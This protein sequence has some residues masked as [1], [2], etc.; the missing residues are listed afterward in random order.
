[1]LLL[2]I[3]L[4]IMTA[5]KRQPVSNQKQM[6]VLSQTN[7]KGIKND[8][9]E[10][11][12][13][14]LE[15]LTSS[16]QQQSSFGDEREGDSVNEIKGDQD[17]MSVHFEHYPLVKALQKLA[18]FR[19]LNIIISKSVQGDLSLSLEGVLWDQAFD[20]ILRSQGLSKIRIGNVFYIAP[21]EEASQQEKQFGLMQNDAP[22][23]VRFFQLNYA[24][25]NEIAALLLNKDQRIL[26]SRG[27][28]A[29]DSR[30][31]GVIVRDTERQI[32]D[33]SDF[34]KRIDIPIK[35]V[36]IEARIV[37][38]D[39]DHEKDL[40]IRFGLRSHPDYSQSH[41]TS[42]AQDNFNMDL[43]LQETEPMNRGI[44]VFRLSQTT[45]LDLE[46]SALE[47]EG[48][49]NIIS[50]P[51]LVTANQQPA[52][53]QSGEEIPYQEF[54]GYQGATKTSFKKAVLSLQVTPQ[55]TPNNK[56]ILNLN[57]SQDK[58]ST[59]EVKGV[60][61]IDTRKLTTQVEVENG[62]TIV[63]GGIYEQTK[64]NGTER[65]PFFSDVPLIGILFKHRKQI[66]SHRELLIFVTP[67]I[68]EK[69]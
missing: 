53:I 28:L 22:L 3:L 60:P 30:T 65:I 13:S 36:L 67:K 63:L 23:A 21:L 37:N 43:P 51:R 31:N 69:A 10:Q 29:V 64:I 39:R 15:V 26:S 20:A 55:I 62:Q 59:Y 7:P 9:L 2:F 66:E 44:A 32:E 58:R 35:Q 33:I 41:L 57:L 12:V 8:S 61:T 38:M 1:M 11:K 68:I 48:K 50:D 24:K 47:S 17:H 4:I 25:A 18:D 42:K 40:G 45:L 54:A 49:A 56:I 52:T 6:P 16:I 19:N 34:I 27:Q 46:L 5:C 14:H